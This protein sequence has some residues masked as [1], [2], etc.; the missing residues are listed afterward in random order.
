MGEPEDF[1]NLLKSKT[2][3]PD[4]DVD[5]VAHQVIGAAIEVPSAARSRIS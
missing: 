2:T 4:P 5:R 1:L 3:E